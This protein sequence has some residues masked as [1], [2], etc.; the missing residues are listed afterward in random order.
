MENLKKSFYD[1][2]LFHYR[3][4]NLAWDQLAKHQQF[5]LIRMYKRKLHIDAISLDDVIAND[6]RKDLNFIS[7]CSDIEKLISRNHIRY[8]LAI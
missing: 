5:V 3:T 8:R 7:E 4:N 2:W 1:Y 6:I